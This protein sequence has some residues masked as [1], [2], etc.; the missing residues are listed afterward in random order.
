K[1]GGE[2]KWKIPSGLILHPAY[3]SIA[4][5]MQSLKSHGIRIASLIGNWLSLER[6]RR[7]RLS[8]TKPSAQDYAPGPTVVGVL[9]RRRLR[10]ALGIVSPRFKLDSPQGSGGRHGP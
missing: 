10:R 5:R 4:L 1:R 8:M 3:R 6:G 7:L 9:R 2:L